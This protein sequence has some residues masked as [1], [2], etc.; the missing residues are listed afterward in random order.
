MNTTTIGEIW[1]VLVSTILVIVWLIRL[2]SKVLY[3]EKDNISRSEKDK[4]IWEK[5]N[6]LQT[7]LT[8]I[9]QSLARLEGRL[10]SKN[11]E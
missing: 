1:P 3:L 5:F 10:E 11:D 6:E 4:M 8:G 2:E 9:L 7:T